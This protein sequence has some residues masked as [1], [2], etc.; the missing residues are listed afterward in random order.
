MNEE[1]FEQNF[2]EFIDKFVL[3]TNATAQE[4]DASDQAI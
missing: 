4:F 3:V 2:N 1:E